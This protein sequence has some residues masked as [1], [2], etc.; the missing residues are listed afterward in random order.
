MTTLNGIL[1]VWKPANVTSHDVVAKVRRLAQQKRVGHTGTLDPAVEGVLPLCLG[2]ATRVVEYVQ[3]LAKTYEGTMTLGIATDTQDQEGQE[4]ERAAVGDVSEQDIRR[5][6]RQFTGEITQTPPMFSAV[7]VDGRRL[8][9]LARE[10]KVVERKART[11]RIERLE[12]LAMRAGAFPEVDFSVTCSKGTYVRTLC[13]DMGAA[14]G[15]P[16]HMSRL[17]RV[18]SGPFCAEQCVTLAQLEETPR[19]KWGERW[20]FPLEAGVAHFP[21]YTIA[22]SDARRVANG[23]PLQLTSGSETKPEAVSPGTL[24]RIYVGDTFRALYLTDAT[25]KQAKAVKVFAE[26]R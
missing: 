8:Y 18:Q 17:V 22:A 24:V 12:L 23:M 15:Y 20:L 19:E 25:G 2:Q 7:K 1:P 3:Q 9:D 13:V 10:G 5:V 11:V 4:L 21:A 26:N 14:L 16:A 6:F